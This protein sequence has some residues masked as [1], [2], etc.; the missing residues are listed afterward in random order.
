MFEKEQVDLIV[1]I[2]GVIL[3]A[4]VVL[5]LLTW[6]GIV[7]CKSV[8]PYWCDAYDFIVGGPRVL[9]VHGDSGLGTPEKLKTYLQDPRF[10]GANAVDLQ[11][12]E[13]IS[14]GTLKK[15]KLVIV[16]Q[17]R[18]LSVEQMEMFQDYVIKFGGR[19]VWVGDS[20]VERPEGEVK[21]LTDSNTGQTLINNPWIRVKETDEAY[22]VIS[23]DEFLGLRYIDTYC[24]EVECN[25]NF[26]TAGTIESEPTGNHPLIFG[27]ASILNFK[28]NKERDFAIVKQISNS[29]NSNIVLYLNFGGNIVGKENTIGKSIPLIATSNIGA[30]GAE[31]VAYYAYPPEWFYEDN[32]YFYYLKNM[33]YGM[34][35][36]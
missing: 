10:V 6:S 31:R 14:L 4:F 15:Y 28:I 5:F 22:N 8:S 23:F 13:R 21:Q 32:N 16:E 26:F 17:A 36:R 24:K 33:Y 2:V 18:M 3:L 25:A 30:G 1:K 19:L 35:G 7:A 9:I 34:L 11:H 27:T 20:G 12:V 29:A